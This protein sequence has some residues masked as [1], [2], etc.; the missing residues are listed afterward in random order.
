MLCCL[1]ILLP[2]FFFPDSVRGGFFNNRLYWSGMN[3]HGIVKIQH[4]CNDNEAEI[5]FECIRDELVREGENR[6]NNGYQGKG[7]AEKDQEKACKQI[8]RE[9]DCIEPECVR[10][11]D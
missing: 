9:K 2:A 5:G 3:F 1:C 6:T 7:I 8:A 10:V 4:C 11:P